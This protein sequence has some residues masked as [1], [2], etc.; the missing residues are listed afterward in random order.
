[1]LL[2]VSGS[3]NL[4]FWLISRQNHEIIFREHPTLYQNGQCQLIYLIKTTLLQLVFSNPSPVL[5]PYLFNP[6]VIEWDDYWVCVVWFSASYYCYHQLATWGHQINKT[7]FS[8][9]SLVVKRM[10]FSHVMWICINPPIDIE[11][12]V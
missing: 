11:V 8:S 7:V 3:L 9:H 1:M 6:S 12:S 5:K 2:V 4:S 10:L